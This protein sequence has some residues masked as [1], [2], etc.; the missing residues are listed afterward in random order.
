MCNI[1]EFGVMEKFF[2]YVYAI[3]GDFFIKGMSKFLKLNNFQWI[4]VNQENKEGYYS[5]K[6][7][8]WEIA[9]DW[10]DS[11]GWSVFLC[12]RFEEVLEEYGCSSKEEAIVIVNKIYKSSVI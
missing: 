6:K 1:K 12:N 8:G 2:N 7:N 5:F 4:I 10:V 9:I 11:K 3:V